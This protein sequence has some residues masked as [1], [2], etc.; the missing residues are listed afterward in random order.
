MIKVIQLKKMDIQL[1]EF[2]K[3]RIMLSADLTDLYSQTAK[4]LYHYNMV[5]VIMMLVVI[6]KLY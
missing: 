6:K 1:V 4:L 2:L 5:N 3:A